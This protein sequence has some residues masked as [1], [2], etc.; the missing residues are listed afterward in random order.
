MRTEA[1]CGSDLAILT[2]PLSIRQPL[3]TSREPWKYDGV[4]RNRPESFPADLERRWRSDGFWKLRHVPPGPLQVLVEH[5]VYVDAR[6]RG[7][8]PA[9]VCSKIISAAQGQNYH[10]LVGVI[11][12]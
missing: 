10:V 11:D 1:S 12:A 9:S 3:I 4:V 7:Q 8:G 2:T 5:S 6:F